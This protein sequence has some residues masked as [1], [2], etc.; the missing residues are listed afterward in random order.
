MFTS[1]AEHGERFDNINS[2]V[3]FSVQVVGRSSVRLGLVYR[4]A[5]S[6][7]LPCSFFYVIY[8]FAVHNT[9]DELKV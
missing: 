1:S 5:L 3:G 6:Y 7:I 9:L 8:F 2:L 4:T